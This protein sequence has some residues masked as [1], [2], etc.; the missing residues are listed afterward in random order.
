MSVLPPSTLTYQ[1]TD[2]P[3]LGDEARRHIRLGVNIIS[4]TKPQWMSEGLLLDTN[5][6]P[7]ARACEHEQSNAVLLC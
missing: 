5:P 1:S 3:V 4:V 7:E 2:W 6:V